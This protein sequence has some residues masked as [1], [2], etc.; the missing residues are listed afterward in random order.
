MN[1][2]RN[3]KGKFAKYDYKIIAIRRKRTLRTIKI[4]AT[5]T[6][7]ALAVVGSQA[8]YSEAKNQLNGLFNKPLAQATTT[9]ELSVKEYI[10]QELTKANISVAEGFAIIECES[11]WN[12]QA[13]NNNGKDYGV[14][15]SL[16]QTNTKYQ[17]QI[18]PNCAFD[19]KC[20]TAE[21]I[22]IYRSRG[23]NWSAWACARILGLDK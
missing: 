5:A 19:Y 11:G 21:A 23:N 14:D 16:W 8:V 20:Q 18:T 4:L 22:K 15:L 10:A 17:P 9:P 6:T 1:Y 7:L 2:K 12:S 3:K 13:I